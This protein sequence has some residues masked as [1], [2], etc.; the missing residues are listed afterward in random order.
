MCVRTASDVIAFLVDDSVLH[1]ALLAGSV[2]VACMYMHKCASVCV[3]GCAWRYMCVL[4]HV[5]AS[6]CLLECP[7]H[8]LLLDFTLFVLGLVDSMPRYVFVP[9]VLDPL[10][11]NSK[12]FVPTPLS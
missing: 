2:K 6:R 8:A 7:P 11:I 10:S 5:R 1:A 3:R 4:V 12:R 9:D